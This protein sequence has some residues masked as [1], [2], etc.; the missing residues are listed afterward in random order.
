MNL[1][2]FWPSLRTDEFESF[3]ALFT[4]DLFE[5]TTLI[6]S[7]LDTLHQYR[8]GSVFRDHF[9]LLSQPCFC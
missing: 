3:L 2:A 5:S 8:S 9:T 6:G 1:R 7:Q 4:Y